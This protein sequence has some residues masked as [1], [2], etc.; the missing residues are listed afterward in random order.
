M[1]RTR[2]ITP[3]SEVAGLQGA[4]G[5]ALNGRAVSERVAEGNAKLDGRRPPA[6]ARSTDKSQAW[7]FER[8]G[9]PRRDVRN[10][11]EFT[12]SHAVSAN[13]LEIRVELESRSDH[14]FFE[15]DKD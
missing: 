9:S 10:D 4:F 3:A 12:R 13:L 11:A 7:L 14:W 1:R 2:S 6:S 15:N 8:T 5:G